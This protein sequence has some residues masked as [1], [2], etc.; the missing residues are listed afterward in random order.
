VVPADI[1]DRSIFAFIDRPRRFVGQPRLFI[2]QP[3]RFIAD[4]HLF[5]AQPL[6]FIDELQQWVVQ[7]WSSLVEPLLFVAEPRRWVVDESLW[8]RDQLPW[9]VDEQPWLDDKQQ[10]ID[11]RR[12]F[13]ADEQRWL[14]DERLGLAGGLRQHIAYT[15]LGDVEQGRPRTRHKPLR[16]H[17]GYPRGVARGQCDSEAH[18]RHPCASVA[19]PSK[20]DAGITQS[21]DHMIAIGRSPA[22]D[23]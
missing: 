11:E 4:R 6:R 21:R 7:P 8:L 5:A 3:R 14:G 9:L 20:S 19:N 1:L 13:I 22:C 18:P 16:R 15:L 17:R 12:L 10:F 23:R 2:D